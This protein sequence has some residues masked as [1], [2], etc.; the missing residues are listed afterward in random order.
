MSEKSD[1]RLDAYLDDR[2]SPSERQ[3]F[4]QTLDSD[5]SLRAIL[6][7]Q[8]AIDASLR[9]VFGSVNIDK[10]VAAIDA[11]A[12][13]AT[14]II[15]ESETLPARWKLMAAAALLAISS[16]GL[17]Y[18]WSISKPAPVADVYAPQPWRSFETVYGDAI[19]NGFKPD[20][21]CRNEREFERTFARRLR[22]PLL[23]AALPAGV[24]AGGISYSNT[25]TESTINVFGRVQGTPVM[26]FVDKAA[27]DLKTMPQPDGKLHVFRREVGS[28]VL[29]ELTPLDQPNILPHFYTPK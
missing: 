21:I 19:R 28:L 2:M 18:S 10:A 29:Y 11:E 12:P 6:E 7:R 24:T 26:V 20:W 25:I 1:P 3:D 14:L 9:R 8:Q 5:P 23:I 17:W 4:R 15:Q 16:A 22:Q 13:G 27:S